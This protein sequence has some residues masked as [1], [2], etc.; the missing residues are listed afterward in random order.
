[1]K[2]AVIAAPALCSSCIGRHEERRTSTGESDK[3][4]RGKGNE[5]IADSLCRAWEATWS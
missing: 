4:G 2:A 3:A 5:S 1:M